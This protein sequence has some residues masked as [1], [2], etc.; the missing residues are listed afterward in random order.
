MESKFAILVV[1]WNSHVDVELLLKA[2]PSHI[3]VVI[4]DNNSDDVINLNE[5]IDASGNGVLVRSNVNGGYGSGMNLAIEYVISNSLAENVLLLNPD[6]NLMKEF[7]EHVSSACGSFDV[8]GFQQFTANENGER[9]FYPCAA[10]FNKGKIK[11]CQRQNSGRSVVDIV[12]GAAML[13]KLSAF[14][15]VGFFDE[16]FFHYK[17]EFDLCFRMK[18]FGRTIAIDYEVPIQHNA[19][20]SLAHGSPSAIYYQVRNEIFFAKKHLAIPKY[21]SLINVAAV[22]R[23]CMSVKVPGKYRSIATAIVDGLRSKSGIRRQ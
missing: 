1:N 3:P 17:E 5:I 22:V 8:L 12:T 15:G 10:Y 7:L 23:N 18:A 11:L 21:R 20:S 16:S 4:V 14:E 9:R 2:V 13:I 6:V 19:G